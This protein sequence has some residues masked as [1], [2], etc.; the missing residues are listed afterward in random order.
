MNSR[1]KKLTE[2][3]ASLVDTVRR[4]VVAERECEKLLPEIGVQR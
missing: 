1:K 4:P 2:K 3:L